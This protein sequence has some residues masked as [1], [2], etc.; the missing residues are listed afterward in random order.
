MDRERE[1]TN[2][3]V[4]PQPAFFEVG[5]LVG[6]VHDD[7]FAAEILVEDVDELSAS[8]F[9]SPPDLAR[10][11]ALRSELLMMEELAPNLFETE[12]ARV[13]DFGHTFSPAIESASIGVDQWIGSTFDPASPVSSATL[14]PMFV[15]LTLIGLGVLGVFLRAANDGPAR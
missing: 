12:H 9:H 11:L 1:S 2:R 13:V 10:E 14:T 3:S 4:E 5:E 6:R 15:L 7:F 8:R